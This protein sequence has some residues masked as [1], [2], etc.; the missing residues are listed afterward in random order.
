MNIGYIYKCTFPDGKV[1]VGQ[2]KKNPLK[3][4]KE[5]LDPSPKRGP[6]NPRF[7]A[8]YLKQGKP[9]LEILE[10]VERKDRDS[11]SYALNVQERKYIQSLKADDPEF[12]C[13]VHPGGGRPVEAEKV[14]CCFYHRNRDYYY[15]EVREYFVSL[16]EKKKSRIPLTDE[17]NQHLDRYLFSEENI[18]C[19]AFK[20]TDPNEER[21]LNREY[22]AINYAA[23]L[24]E[25][26]YGEDLKEYIEEHQDEILAEYYNSKTILQL[27]SYGNILGEYN[28]IQEIAE[29][30]KCDGE[31]VRHVLKGN[32]KTAYGYRWC[33]KKDYD[34]N[35]VC[36]Q[37]LLFPLE[38]L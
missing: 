16:L 23:S 31:S 27:D 1:Y 26:E 19:S 14:L 3:R 9:S 6:T 11:L 38:L 25:E 15:T 13:N 37:Q 29:K 35:K 12:G 17:E 4:Y 36:Q 20:E 32:Q 30:L 21:Q 18:F 22:E 24:C 7:W 10:K 8:E 5:H 33:Y 2:T 34:S 28:D